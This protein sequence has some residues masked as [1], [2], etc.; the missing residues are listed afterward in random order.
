MTIYESLR[1]YLLADTGIAAVVAARVY[2]PGGSQG[3]NRDQII[4]QGIDEVRATT[5]NAVGS[6]AERRFQVTSWSPSYLSAHSLG[7]LVRQ[8]LDG[9]NLQ[10]SDG[11]SPETL[12][13]VQIWFNNA[14]DLFQGDD[15]VSQPMHGHAADY[16]VSHGTAGGAL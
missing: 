7:A 5:L 15:K 14:T 10:W 16:L 3:E 12:V 2:P 13:F 4:I 6:R 1:A 9:K 8:R 11:A